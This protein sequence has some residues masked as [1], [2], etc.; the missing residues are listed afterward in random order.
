MV[1]ANVIQYSRTFRQ[2]RIVHRVF[3]KNI[4]V[5]LAAKDDLDINRSTG[6]YGCFSG[7]CQPAEIRKAIDKIEGKPEPEWVK[8][9]RSK[10]RTEFFYSDRNGNPLVKV[11]RVDPGDG[12]KKKHSQFHWTV[13]RGWVAGNPAR[14]KKLIPIYRYAEVRSAIER[15]ELIFV[16]E[17]E[18][19]ADALWKLGIAA[20]TTIGGTEGYRRYGTYIDDLSGA[21]L[22]LCP[23]RDAPGLKYI[24]AVDRDFSDRVEG[25]VLAGSQGL[26]RQPQGGMDIGDEILDG[27]DLDRL[28]GKIISGDEYRAATKPLPKGENK[29]EVG[30]QKPP[31]PLVTAKT[32]ECQEIFDTLKYEAAIDQWWEYSAGQWRP[33][34]HLFVFKKLQDFLEQEVHRLSAELY[35]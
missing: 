31:C 11:V 9:I 6:A 30:K 19:V 3:D 2:F 16:V 21:R 27:I 8:P 23:D 25:F 17:G 7:G 1:V 22:I 10:A 20:T 34:H 35:R 24:A 28:L 32:M 26:W 4:S 18:A 5:R 33:I 14:V 15:G 13:E 12:S 29:T